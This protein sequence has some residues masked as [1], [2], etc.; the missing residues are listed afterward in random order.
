MLKTTT[1]QN[2]GNASYLGATG[3]LPLVIAKSAIPFIYLSSG[4]MG[5]NGAL[6]AITALSRTYGNA[7][8]WFSANQIAAGVAAGWYY[9]RFSSTTAATIFNNTYTTGTP[10][11]PSSPT[12]FATTGPG[13]ITGQTTEVFGPQISIAANSM[14]PTGQVRITQYAICA[15]NANVKTL[16]IRFTGTGGTVIFN[17]AITSTV[18]GGFVSVTGNMGVTNAQTTYCAST[19]NNASGQFDTGSAIDTTAAT[20]FSLSATRATATDNI[21]VEGFMVEL[22]PG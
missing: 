6:S 9:G 16:V 18:G 3:S 4:T 21:V 12:A 19:F 15:N 14:G 17:P 10:A 2:L 13:A 1:R 22:I 20:V 11:V 8:V 7:Y 5:N